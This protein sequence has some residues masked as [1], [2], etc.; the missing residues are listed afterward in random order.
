MKGIEPYFAIIN[1]K[2]LS[3]WFDVYSL[4][5]AILEAREDDFERHGNLEVNIDCTQ[6]R[7]WG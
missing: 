3:P 7:R 6:E 5:C 1:A 2:I 4:Y